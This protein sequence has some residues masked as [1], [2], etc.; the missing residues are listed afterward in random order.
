MES[1]EPCES[2]EL[3]EP[4]ESTKEFLSLTNPLEDVKLATDNVSLDNLIECGESGQL[5]RGELS[6]PEGKS[7]VCLKDLDCRLGQGNIEFS[8]TIM[9][10]VENK[11]ENTVSISGYCEEVEE[12]ILLYENASSE[13]LSNQQDV[14]CSIM[15]D[16]AKALIV[17]FFSFLFSETPTF[18]PPMHLHTNSIWE[19]LSQT[20]TGV[21]TQWNTEFVVLDRVVRYLFQYVIELYWIQNGIELYWIVKMFQLGLSKYCRVSKEQQTYLF[22]DFTWR[23]TSGHQ[24]IKDHAWNILTVRK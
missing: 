2:I 11:H 17:C 7:K 3:S 9:M 8:E 18:D 5:Y 15:T 14:A 1:L 22:P 13:S 12:K 23:G 4:S 16:T 20:E 6:L 10:F 21:A 24:G 19:M